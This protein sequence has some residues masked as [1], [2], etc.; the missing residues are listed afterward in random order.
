VTAVVAV[1]GETERAAAVP[2]GLAV[3]RVGGVTVELHPSGA[4]W[5]ST[6]RTLVVADLHFE[7][8]SSF[9]RF[10]QMLPPYD[11]AVTL[12]RLEA[13]MAALSPDRVVALGDSFHDRGGAARLSPADLARL[14]ALVGGREWLWITGNHDPEISDHVGGARAADA[15]IGGLVLR[16][17][18]SA[19]FVDGEVCGHLHPALTV[20][21]RGRG[22]RRRCFA[23][24]GHRLV[25]P[26][27]GSLAGGLDLFDQAFA[28]VLSRARTVAHLIGAERLYRIPLTAARGR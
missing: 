20:V 8:A 16:H 25:L 24:D 1:A 13:V 7:K 27:F 14:S 11:T 26:A 5:L 17:E 9:A 28:R 23:T 3:A 2:A 10:G 19:T 15:E 18:P 12:T 6:T 21:G 4:L 22:V